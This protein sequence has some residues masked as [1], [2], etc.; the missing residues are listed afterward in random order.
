MSVALAPAPP[1]ARREAEPRVKTCDVAD[2]LRRVVKPDDPDAGESV[3][4]IAHKASCST[5][6]V[7]RVLSIA[8]ETINLDL[9]DRLCVAADGHISDCRLVDNRGRPVQ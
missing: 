7:Y 4:L 6:T 8:T 2:I 5:R 3:E 9:A 1:P